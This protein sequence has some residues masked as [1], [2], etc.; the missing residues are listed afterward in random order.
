MTQIPQQPQPVP[1]EHTK[2]CEICGKP[3][4]VHVGKNHQHIAAIMEQAK[5]PWGIQL[6]GVNEFTRLAPE[7]DVII[8]TQCVSKLRRMIISWNDGKKGLDKPQ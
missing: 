6:W 7:V 2:G 5:Q 4:L 3:Y 1:P 8:C